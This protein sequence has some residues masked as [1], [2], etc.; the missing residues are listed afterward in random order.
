MPSTKSS[1]KIMYDLARYLRLT[2]HEVSVITTSN[3]ITE[4][5]EIVIEDGIQILRVKS[6]KINGANKLVRL[7]NEFFLSSRIWRT[8]KNF[9][10]NNRCDL[11]IWY[12][13][14]IFFGPLIKKLKSHYNCSGYLV[15][16][17]IFPQW[18]LDTGI[19]RRGIVYFF[20]RIYEKM[21]YD[22]ADFIGVQS[23][24]N[25]DYFKSGQNL[26][27]ENIE[28]L[29]NWV[30]LGEHIVEQ[31]D[32]RS[33]LNL[34]NKIIFFYGGNIGEAQSLDNIISLAYD[35]RWNEKL[36][37]LIIGDG[38]ESSRLKKKIESLELSNI[39]ILSSVSQHIYLSI[40]ASIDVGIISLNPKFKTQ[41]FPGKM[42][43]YMFYSKP[44]LAAINR[45]NDL[46]DLI[47]TNNVGL[48]CLSSDK[49]SLLNNALKLAHDAELR[50]EMGSNGR[51]LLN[52]KFS[53][54]NAAT[55]ILSHFI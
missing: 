35:T 9:I 20:L 47:L 40:V 27:T 4:T 24:K 32:I 34:E 18:A 53:V 55:Q 37:Y 2:G 3:D 8:G 46:E 15:L 12:S 22:L 36:F 13:P 39:K 51:R 14:T 50:K 49:N 6:G 5:H 38:S 11:V 28:V 44:I 29:Y 30:D 41:N 42:L 16:R 26:K 45:G 19:L 21:Q 25:L 23:P 33:K 52:E 17:D 7:Y 10:T 54:K 43:S 31:S 48:V 1:A